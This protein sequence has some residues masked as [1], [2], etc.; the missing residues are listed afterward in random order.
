[1]WHRGVAGLL[2]LTVCGA[3]LTP[4]PNAIS[5]NVAFNTSAVLPLKMIGYLEDWVSTPPS[6]VISQYTHVIYSFIETSSS[7]CEL[8]GPS[9]ATVQKLQAMGVKVMAS[10]GGASMNKYWKYCSVNSLVSQTLKIVQNT[11]LDGIDIDYEIEPAN[12]TFLVALS[13]GIRA[14]LASSKL[15]S[16]APQSPDMEKGQSYWRALQECNGVDFINIQYYNNDPN[17]ITDPS[18]CISHYK[19]VVS[20][21]FAGDSTKVAFGF[22]IKECGKQNSN[23]QF[24]ASFTK[25]IKSAIGSTFGG[26]FNWAIN[27]G[28]SDGAWSKAVDQALRG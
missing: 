21:L 8:S 13:N 20:G 5:G 27:S 23:A 26:V 3:I 10:L 2:A 7:S 6:S 17:P 1:M 28:D 9:A 12:V 22:C 16:H 14:G 11:N 19:T 4:A 18:G 15:L 25:Q 24:A